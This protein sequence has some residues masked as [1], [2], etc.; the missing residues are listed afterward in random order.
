MS[1]LKQN[2]LES[3]TTDLGFVQAI[4]ENKGETIVA[5][6]KEVTLD[7]GTVVTVESITPSKMKQVLNSMVD[8]NEGAISYVTPGEV[9]VERDG[10][11][12]KYNDSVVEPDLVSIAVT[13]PPTKTEYVEGDNFDATGMVVTATYS[14]ETTKP[15]TDYT[16]SPSENLATTDTSVTISYGGK[17]ATQAITVIES[18]LVITSNKNVSVDFHSLG[19]DLVNTTLSAQLEN[20]IGTMECESGPFLEISGKDENSTIEFYK[21]EGHNIIVKLGYKTGESTGSSI[22]I[23]NISDNAAQS[24]N[25]IET[26]SDALNVVIN[27]SNNPVTIDVSSISTGVSTFVKESTPL[28]A[29]FYQAE[30]YNTTIDLKNYITIS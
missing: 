18:D 6:Q 16:V 10:V 21:S 12:Q 2:N 28:T 30:S 7:D 23:A 27:Y 5:L 25:L 17:T 20:N 11:V 13:T 14:N 15:V 4:N 1:N 8:G 29:N 24:E 3:A 22:T 9:Y 26:L 19:T